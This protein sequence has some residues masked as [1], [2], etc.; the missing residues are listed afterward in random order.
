MEAS[1]PYT[2][3]MQYIGEAASGSLPGPAWSF[4]RQNKWYTMMM[5]GWQPVGVKD[6]QFSNIGRWVKDVAEGEW[7]PYGIM[8][9]P[10]PATSFNV[11][12]GFLEHFGN[13]GRSVR[14]M[15]RR[16]GYCR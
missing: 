16:L 3:P 2:Y 15:H 14:S 10:L 5:R 4:I 6:A 13:G 12:A 7:H 8:R 1:S 9:L 11:N